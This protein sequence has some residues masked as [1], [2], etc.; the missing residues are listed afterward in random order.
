MKKYYRLFGFEFKGILRDPISLLL[1]AFP[2]LLLFLSCFV[3]PRVLR[4]LHPWKRLPPKASHC[5]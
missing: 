4:T 3:I 5:S 2:A 1:L